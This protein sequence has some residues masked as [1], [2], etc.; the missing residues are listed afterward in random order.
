M[1]TKISI[2][3]KQL[4]LDQANPSE[5][6]EETWLYALRNGRPTGIPGGAKTGK[7]LLF[8]A[9]RNIDV[10]WMKVKKATEE[11]LLGQVSK[12]STHHRLQ[13]LQNP[14]SAVICVYVDDSRN[15]EDML[16][17]H[18]TLV[19]LGFPEKCHSSL[20]PPH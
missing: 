12:V 18:S 7:Y 9:L 17:I 6:T 3:E 13:L 11:G 19:E 4:D 20:T 5:T 2:A 15:E 14:S 8:A 10:V 1:P 16:R